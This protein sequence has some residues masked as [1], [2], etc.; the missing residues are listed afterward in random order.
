VDWY[1][2]LKTGHPKT[3]FKSLLPLTDTPVRRSAKARG[4]E[5]SERV[6]KTINNR[7]FRA[8]T[9]TSKSVELDSASQ[10]YD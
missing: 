2:G 9:T 7:N 1:R 8:G 4:A 3:A 10:A 5:K 6:K